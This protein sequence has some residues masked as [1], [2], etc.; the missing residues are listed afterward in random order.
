MK[1]LGVGIGIVLISIIVI[2][3]VV[4]L[5]YGDNVVE[6]Q[7]QM[8]NEESFQNQPTQSNCPPVEPPVWYENSPI[9]SI[10]SR[11]TGIGINVC[12]SDSINCDV[13][14]INSSYLINIQT[15]NDEIPQ[16]V[17]T[18]KGNGS[19]T[20]EIQSN[21]PE[22][23]WKIIKINNATDFGLYSTENAINTRY[24]Y[25]LCLKE[26]VRRTDQGGNI[27][28][29]PNLALQYENGSISVRLLGD[30]ES[31]KWL[32]R[33]TSINQQPLNILN[34]ISAYSPEYVD[35][36]SGGSNFMGGGI[37]QLNAAS[38]MQIMQSLNQIQKM[39]GDQNGDKPPSETTFGDVPISVNLRLGGNVPDMPSSTE[40]VENGNEGFQSTSRINTLLNKFENEDQEGKDKETL[41]ALIQK[42]STIECK[43]PNFDDY[44]TL[45]QMA[46]CHA[47]SEL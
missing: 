22:Q 24:P 45:S 32:I 29:N 3:I 19:F 16:G 8:G 11:Y 34:G 14:N 43:V 4:K 36:S 40:T 5:I 30:F 37:E 15:P 21:S 1:N 44:V 13:G 28:D 6:F 27:G 42:D 47:C 10:I 33:D 38:Q 12:A 17:L 41:N 7:F 25:Y 20:T 35:P 23:M 39:L 9:S 46:S 26:P 31:Q 18:V 2:I